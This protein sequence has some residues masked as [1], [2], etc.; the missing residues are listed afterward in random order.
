MNSNANYLNPLLAV[1]DAPSNTTNTNTN[2]A[3][4]TPPSTP[5]NT[6]TNTNTTSP[7]PT[8]GFCISGQR[9]AQDN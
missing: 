2:T 7:T 4:P 9:P 8:P 3:T 6:G 1:W 5:T